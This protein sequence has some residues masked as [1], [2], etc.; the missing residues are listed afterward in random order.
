MM[1]NSSPAAQRYRAS[2]MPLMALYVVLLFGVIS[3]IREQP[4]TGL[5]RYA[6]A[7]LPALPLVGVLWTM[8]RYILEEQDEYIRWL[9]VRAMLV[10]TGLVLAVSTV[11]GFLE[12]LA[13]APH[14]PAYL[15]FPLWCGGLGVGQCWGKLRP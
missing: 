2:L 10:A 11:W 9:A 7:L 15:W 14:I 8:G 12:A 3:L 13:D 1:Y 5:L 4:V 6:L